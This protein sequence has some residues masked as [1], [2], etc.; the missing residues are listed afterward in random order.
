MRQ[1]ALAR[2]VSDLKFEDLPSEVVEKAKEIALHTWGVQLAASTLPWCKAAYRFV[3]SQGGVRESTVVNYGLRTSPT[4]ASFANSTFGHGFEMDDNYAAAGMKGGCVIVPPALALGEGRLSTGRELLTAIVAGFEVL[5]RVGLTVR[6]FRRRQGYHGT[7]NVGAFGA[8]AAGGKILGFSEDLMEQTIGGAAF[9]S[10]GLSEAPEEG[11]GHMKRTFA[12]M[13]SSA[14][15]RAALLAREGLTG[16][17]TAL[18]GV[19]GFAKAFGGQEANLETLTRD[20]G[21]TWEILDVHYKVYAQDGFIQP[22]TQAL[23]AIR[24]SHPFEVAD[25][26]EVR[27]GTHRDAR[28]FTVGVIRKPHDITSAQFSA[29]FSAALFLVTG[30]AGFHEYTEENLHNPEILELSKR[31]HVEV[32]DE[33]QSEWEK[34]QPRGAK[35]TVKLRSG[36]EFQEHVPD[37]RLLTSVE[38]DDKVKG[39]ASVALSEDRASHLVDVARNLE[40]LRDVSALARLLGSGQSPTA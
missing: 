35:V 19:R 26:E 17:A 6:D 25:I 29:Y 13:A 27:L 33:I 3:R 8:A 23:A 2:F 37:L 34:H 5:T 36:E 15:V 38:V 16:P 40:E 7:G 21:S 14:G 18:D 11:R 4:N 28:D 22:M 30:G 1:R 9:N 20:L 39:L 31:V 24:A 12:G 10:S 32:D